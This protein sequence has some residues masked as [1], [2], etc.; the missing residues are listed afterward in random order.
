MSERLEGYHETLPIKR[1]DIV[2][3]KKGTMI[4]TVGKEPRPA[5]KTYKIKVDH[6]LPGRSEIKLRQNDTPPHGFWEERINHEN[7]KVVWPGPGG[8]WSEADINDVEKVS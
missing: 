3:I 5:G 4:K 6:T 7:P 1:G 2:L 8:Y